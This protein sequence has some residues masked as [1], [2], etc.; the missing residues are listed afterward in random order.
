MILDAVLLIVWLVV[1]S[2]GSALDRNVGQTDTTLLPFVLA[3]NTITAGFVLLFKG[4]ETAIVEE[5]AIAEGRF[6]RCIRWTE[7]IR[8]GALLCKFCG[9]EQ[10]SV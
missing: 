6:K 3:L 4:P 7:A 9:S 1:A 2:G 8:S 10:R 5:T